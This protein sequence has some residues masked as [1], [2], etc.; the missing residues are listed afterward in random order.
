[1]NAYT[2]AERGNLAPLRPVARRPVGRG[3]RIASTVIGTGLLLAG[4]RSLTRGRPIR[5]AALTALGGMLTSRGATGRCG[6][7][8][9]L[10]VEAD[11]AYPASN[12]MSRH[13]HV[14][15]S[16]AIDAP[17]DQIYARWRDIGSLPRLLSHVN[18]VDVID[19]RRSRWY[20]EAPLG[21]EVSWEAIIEEDKPG[22]LISWRST[23]DS[24]V[25]T[26]GRVEFRDAPGGRGTIMLV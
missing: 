15:D 23:P 1:M 19:E 25:E 6:A 16:V 22:R 26:E 20:A 7:Y 10:G 3:E 12:P 8:R 4:A 11:D 13:I 5:A 24:T 2:T 17:S 9:S 18:R 21:G 14:R